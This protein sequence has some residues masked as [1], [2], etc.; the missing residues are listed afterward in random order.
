MLKIVHVLAG[1]IALLL[2]FIPSLRGAEPCYCNPKPC[3]C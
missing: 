1:V 3:A 2:S